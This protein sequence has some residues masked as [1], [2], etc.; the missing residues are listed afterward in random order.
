MEDL[1]DVERDDFYL[2]PFHWIITITA[3][4][5]FISFLWINRAQTDTTPNADVQIKAGSR[6]DSKCNSPNCARCNNLATTATS[7]F[8]LRE[9]LRT[10][11]KIFCQTQPQDD[12]ANDRIR[13]LLEYSN[14]KHYCILSS[15]Y[16]ESGYELNSRD[17]EE[18]IKSLPYIWILPGLDRC[19]FWS[20]EMYAS[21]RDMTSIFIEQ[22]NLHAVQ[23]EFKIVNSYEKGWKVNSVPS[24][25][26]RVYHLYNQGEKVDE[27]C[28]HCPITV[29]LLDDLPSFMC[30]HMFGN[31]MFSVL[32]PGSS[33][34]PHTGPCNYRLRC[35]LPL[36]T[37]PG[38]MIK[39]GKDVS[40]W[41][42][43]KL[44]IFDDSFV[45]EVWHDGE[46]NDLNGGRAV[47]IFDIWHPQVTSHEQVTIKYIY[48][49]S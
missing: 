9:K 49:Q 27:N 14:E 23:N 21:L 41:E 40:S 32:E 15:M 43:G 25:R 1:K 46:E 33:I 48:S 37:P 2:L 29:G 24:G 28:I 45:H 35:H 12:A 30:H 17:E 26:W 13:S 5:L 22:E 7:F 38:Y 44:M 4:M 11:F 3:C 36:V 34:E 6:E 18:I 39:V 16:K 42:E 10:R 31:A 8:N 47:L 19:T 20:T